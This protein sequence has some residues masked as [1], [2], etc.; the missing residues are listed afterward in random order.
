MAGWKMT[1]SPIVVDRLA[2]LGPF[3]VA[4]EDRLSLR[5]GPPRGDR[6][7]LA[8]ADFND[9]DQ[10]CPVNDDGT[11][12]ILLIF[13]GLG[14]ISVVFD[15]NANVALSHYPPAAL[16]RGLAHAQRSLCFF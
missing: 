12:R 6:R 14:V 2:V 10:D 7:D 15:L 8:T 4:S 3:R 1:G 11:R 5:V 9:M 16:P 13:Q